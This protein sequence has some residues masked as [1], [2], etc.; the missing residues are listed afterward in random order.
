MINQL[1]PSKSKRLISLDAFRGI[2]IAGMILVNNPGSWK[3]VYSP[4]R[5]AEWHGCTPTD[6]VFPFFLFIVGVAIPFSFGKRLERGE[7]QKKLFLRVLRRSLILFG[8][9]LF[10][11][12][13]PTYPL[14]TIRIPGVLQR[15]AVVYFFASMVVIKTGR[16]GETLTIITILTLYWA[17]MKLVPVPG[18]GAGIMEMSGNLASYLD[19]LLLKAHLWKPAWDPEGILST[20]PAIATALLG[21]KTGHWLR[22][23]RSPIEKTV[24]LFVGGNIGLVLGL[25]MNFWFPINKGL[26]TSSYVIYTAGMALNF[27]G[28]CYW[29]IDV[30]G[31]RRWATPFV[32]YGMNAIT[33]FFLSGLMARLTILWKITQAD[34]TRITLKTYFYETLYA[35][36][37]GPTLGSLFYALT[38]I[39]LWLGLMAILYRKKIFIKI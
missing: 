10:L 4:L 15:I 18:Y 34:G 1:E 33:L 32:I 37:A 17:L 27:L 9:G 25:I 3:F 38:Y 8:L 29:L 2:T 5:H 11:N 20:L 6:L 19:S 30:K 28:I 26:W 36:W 13:F 14:A 24:G 31:Y 12:G 21:V 23:S 22:S 7:S 39:L 16:K 35:P